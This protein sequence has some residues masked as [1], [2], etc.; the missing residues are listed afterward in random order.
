VKRALTRS[1]DSMGGEGIFL[2]EKR[3][4]WKPV[5]FRK[6]QGGS[7]NRCCGVGDLP[8]GFIGKGL[9]GSGGEYTAKGLKLQKKKRGNSSW[10]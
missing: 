4:G 9:G 3:R 2:K 5:S 10:G 1:L 7:R 6:N 8:R